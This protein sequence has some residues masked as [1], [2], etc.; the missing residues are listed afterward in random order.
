MPCNAI[1]SK[2]KEASRVKQKDSNTEVTVSCH[3]VLSKG[4]NISLMSA[5]LK[6]MLCHPLFMPQVCPAQCLTM[7]ACANCMHG[8]TL[9]A[10]IHQKVHHQV[11]GRGA[12]PPSPLKA[13]PESIPSLHGIMISY[14]KHICSIRHHHLF[15]LQ[16]ESDE[17][18]A[19]TIVHTFSP[20]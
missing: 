1:G 12:L 3:F 9:C 14:A 17:V 20:L 16:V 2:G 18:N 4:Y 7:P 8:L 13:T 19:V 10:C 15:A 5:N 11:W 6:S